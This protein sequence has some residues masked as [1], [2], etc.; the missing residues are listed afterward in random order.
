[1]GLLGK[2][3]TAQ[4]SSGAAMAH[5]S[6]I[7]GGCAGM[8]INCMSVEQGGQPCHLQTYSQGLRLG[9]QYDSNNEQLLQAKSP[10]QHA[11]EQ[12]VTALVCCCHAA[13][14]AL[15][16]EVGDTIQ[17][18]LKNNLDFPVNIMPGGIGASV[19]P[20]VN[21]GDTYTAK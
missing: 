6:S 14:P 1:M 7:T 11:C 8:S 15:H 9:W 19:A 2:L 17:V 3:A 12:A 13:G 20:L 18:V 5:C 4:P 10:C 16:G 21:P